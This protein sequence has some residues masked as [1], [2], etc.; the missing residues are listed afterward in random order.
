MEYARTKLLLTGIGVATV[1]GI[2]VAADST[3]TVTAPFAQVARSVGPSHSNAQRT[4]TIASVSKPE[5]GSN[6]VVPSSDIDAAKAVPV[7]PLSVGADWGSEV[8]VSRN[9]SS[10]PS[11]SIRVPRDHRHQ[12]RSGRPAV[13][14]ARSVAAPGSGRRVGVRWGAGR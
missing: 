7:T 14:A 11:H 5:R 10:C 12:R 13:P 4:G 6:C 8:R 9:H 1:G 2:A 3:N